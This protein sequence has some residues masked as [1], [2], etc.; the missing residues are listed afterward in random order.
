MPQNNHLKSQSFTTLGT[1]PVD[2]VNASKTYMMIYHTIIVPG[3]FL[4]IGIF[5]L[6]NQTPSHQM[7]H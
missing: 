6:R 2:H 4:D 3:I 7:S 5:A 1:K